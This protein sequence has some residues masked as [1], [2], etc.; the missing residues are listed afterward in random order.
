M[1]TGTPRNRTMDIARMSKR[2]GTRLRLDGSD[3]PCSV[4]AKNRVTLS[5]APS[6]R[7]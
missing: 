2:S 1:T 4:S 5:V 3:S 7:M 6:S